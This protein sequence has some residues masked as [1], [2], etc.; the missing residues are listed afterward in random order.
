MISNKIVKMEVYANSLDEFN[1]GHSAIKVKVMAQQSFLHLP[2]YKL[3]SPI[4]YILCYEK[5]HA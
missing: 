2:Q 3:I 5:R 1:T 4:S